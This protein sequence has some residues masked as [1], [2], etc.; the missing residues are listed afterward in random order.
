[1]SQRQRFVSS[2]GSGDVVLLKGNDKKNYLNDHVKTLVSELLNKTVLLVLVWLL[3]T[4]V[5]LT[6]SQTWGCYH[7]FWNVKIICRLP[8]TAQLWSSQQRQ[9]KD[10]LL[11]SYD[12]L[13]VEVDSPLTVLLLRSEDLHTQQHAAL[14]CPKWTR[15][16]TFSVNV[17]WRR[18]QRS[19]VT[20]LLEFP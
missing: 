4:F 16:H 8:K 20:R 12:D 11:W 3:Y 2:P 10:F 6:Q 7:S 9:M 19:R 18:G 15:S 5:Q 13:L 17:S 1:M 14:C